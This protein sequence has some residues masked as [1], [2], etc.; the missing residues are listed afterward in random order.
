MLFWVQK[1]LLTLLTMPNNKIALRKQHLKEQQKLDLQ[2]Q[3]Q[4][5][6]LIDAEFI[7]FVEQKAIK[8]LALY[9]AR[10]YEVATLT[11]IKDALKH[12]IAVYL[13]KVN[14]DKT[15]DFYQITDPEKDLTFN[16][17]LKIWEPI[18]QKTLLLIQKSQLDAYVLPLI[19][20]DTHLNRIGSGQGY[21]D[22]YFNGWNYQGLVVGL[23]FESQHTKQLI[24]NELFDQPLNL[25]I[26][27]KGV[28]SPQWGE[29]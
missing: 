15:M 23:A 6:E 25:V 21:Y 20:F 12:A 14:Q 8:S 7:N 29:E 28:Y 16:S 19:C 2:Y 1:G 3:T 26:S 13:P 4:A 11:M 22:H 5:Q 24:D 17:A 18:P 27:E 10:T 9:V